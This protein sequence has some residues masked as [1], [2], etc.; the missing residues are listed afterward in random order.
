MLLINLTFCLLVPSL[1]LTV[2]RYGVVREFEVISYQFI[3]TF[4][5]SNKRLQTSE[6]RM[7]YTGC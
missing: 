2:C 3:P 7:H 4:F 1:P 5:T 6:T